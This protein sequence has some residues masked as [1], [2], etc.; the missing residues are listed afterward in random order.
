MKL[1]QKS[2]FTIGLLL[3]FLLL[4]GISF[5]NTNNTGSGLTSLKTSISNF[6]KGSKSKDGRYKRKKGFLWGLFKRKSA[7]DCPKH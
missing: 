7:C 6:Q 1:H 2:F 4:G 5:A 3:S